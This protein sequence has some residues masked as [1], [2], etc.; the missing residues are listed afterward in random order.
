[1]S[2]EIRNG[3]EFE[4]GFRRVHVKDSFSL[5]NAEALSPRR[6]IMDVTCLIMLPGAPPFV[7][8]IRRESPL[9]QRADSQPTDRCYVR[10]P[11]VACAASAG[12]A[13][14]RS[15]PAPDGWNRSEEHTSELQSRFDLVCRLRL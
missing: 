12:L 3:D 6:K 10:V 4:R 14:L 5:N 8:S 9:G 15:S 2:R 13:P 11:C 7:P 1:D